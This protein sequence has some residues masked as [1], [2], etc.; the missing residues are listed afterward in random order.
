[1]LCF[2]ATSADNLPSILR[3][4]LKC[5]SEKIWDVSEDGIYCWSKH[6]IRENHSE[7]YDSN[8]SEHLSLLESQAMDYTV[9]P[10]T[11]AKDCRGVVVVFEVADDE[12]EPD[13][14]CPGMDDTSVVFRDISPSEIRRII[15]SEDVSIMRGC[16]VR[17][18]MG[19]SMYIRE[20]SEMEKMAAQSMECYDFY[21]TSVEW[22]EV[23]LTAAG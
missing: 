3:D 19:R 14:S 9:V 16:F 6:F 8:N 15:I 4:G 23:D 5:R 10:L 7:E 18:M 11:H 12:V 20:F 2:H 17:M 22:D 21:M 1:M 13:E